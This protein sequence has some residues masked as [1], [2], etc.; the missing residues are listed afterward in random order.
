MK[1]NLKNLALVLLVSTL[2]IVGCQEA[3][4]P[5]APVDNVTIQDINTPPP[6]VKFLKLERMSLKGATPSSTACD[7]ATLHPSVGGTVGGDETFG[8]MVYIPAGSFSKPTTFSVCANEGESFSY[9]DFG[10]S[11]KFKKKV[12]ITLDFSEYDLSEG[13]FA[14]LKIYYWDASRGKN[15]RWVMVNNPSQ[16]DKTEETIS[17]WVSHFSRYAFGN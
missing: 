3:L 17:T 6:G 11:M 4:S 15:G 9:V 7:E 10:P 1:T 13:E 12:Y 16:Y 14:S 5:T 2:T 8:N